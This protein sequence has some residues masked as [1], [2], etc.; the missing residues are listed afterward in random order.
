MKMNHAANKNVT[1]REKQKNFRIISKL[2]RGL[3]L[4]MAF[5]FAVAPV[6]PSCFAGPAEAAAAP[7][8]A[9]SN[10]SSSCALNSARGQIQH[11]IYVQFDNL[12]F[13]RDNPNVPS[14]LELMPTLLSFIEGQGVLLSNH[15]TPLISHTANDILTSLTGVYPDQHG[16]PVANSF[17][18]FNPNGTT[19]PGVSFAYWTSPLFDPSISSPFTPTDTTF[20]ML[21]AAGNNAPAPWVP[22][23]RAGCNFGSV[24]T[25]N[26]ILENIRIDIPT[27]FGANSPEAMEVTSNPVQAFADFVGIGI[28]CA[29]GASLCS[30]D[31][32]GLPDLLR[33]EPGGYS[34]FNG[35]FGHKYVAAQISPGVPLT[36]LNGNVIQDASGHVGFPGFDGMAAAVSL[37]YVAAMQEHGVP[38]TYAYISDAHDAHP[39]G[40][41]LGPGQAQY[42]AALQAYD[43]AFASFFGRLANDGITSQNTL[44]VFTSDEGDHFVGGAPSPVGCDGVTT[45]CSYSQIGELNGN[46]AGLLATQQGITTAFKVHSDSAPAVYITGHPSRDASVTRAFE[47]ATGKLAAVNPITGNTDTIAQA[48]ADP[49]E[50]KLLHMITADPPR[51]PTFVLFADPNYFLF[52]GA[53]NCNSPCVTEQPGFAWN[54]GDFQSD[55]TTTW[56]GMV[57]PGVDQ[58]GVDS[59][60]WSDHADIRPTILTLLGLQDDYTH[61][62]RALAEK[63]SGWAIPRAVRQSAYFVSLA[64]AL[65]QIDAPVGP[66]GLASLRASTAGLESN[67]AGDATYNYVEGQL[68]S[69]TSQRDALAAQMLTLLEG[70]A[71]NNQPIQ[72]QDA[73]QLIQQAQTLL[74]NVQALANNP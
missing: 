64:Q 31:N 38:I 21:T 23:T 51:T 26:T 46:L 6:T 67:D 65:K 20:N 5:A 68:D 7:P 14:D 48:M 36:D 25:A 54:H 45:P 59:V 9:N 44:F 29:A 41:A 70:A 18:Y 10:S 47:R 53:P 42:V 16:V 74:N 3:A 40:P 22:Y 73:I 1:G 63:F 35:L 27:V 13:T 62:G 50:L 56:L 72:D 33:A 30:A 12:H 61:E 71:F 32:K 17:R 39:S 55:I 2:R 11:L 60:T 43:S 19:N 57:G 49:V 8:R 37:S 66:L 52:A 34:G 4:A 28:H 69:F 24:A 58:A 15:H